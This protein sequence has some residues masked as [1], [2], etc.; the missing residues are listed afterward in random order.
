MSEHRIPRLDASA[1]DEQIRH[2]LEREGCVILEE[3]IDHETID[4][5]LSELRPY[6]ER[7]PTGNGDFSGFHTKRLHSLFT[8]S[9]VLAEFIL[10]PNVKQAVDVALLPYCDN[11]Q[12]NSNSI[13]AI[14]PAETVQPLHR[15]DLLYPLSHPSERNAC[16]TAFWALTDFTEENGATR[17]I[18]G[19]HHWDDLRVPEES[20]T[21]QAVMPKGSV[22][23]FVG[24]VYHGGG[25]NRTADEW[26]IGMFQGYCLGWLRQEQN[27]YLSVPPDEARKMPEELA[28]LLGYSVHRPYLGWVFDLQDPWQVING[29]EELSRG[30]GRDMLARGEERMEQGRSVRRGETPTARTP[31]AVNGG[32]RANAIPAV[33][34]NTD[35]AEMQGLLAEAGCLIVRNVV[36]ADTIDA[37]LSDLQ[38]WLERKPKGET[39]FIGRETKR[40]F[41]LL[42]KT[43]R[44][45]DFIGHRTVLDLVDS[46]LGPFCDHFQLSTNSI[47]AI[48]P[49]ETAQSLH[50]GDALYPLPH[51]SERNLSCTAVWALGDFSAENGATLIVPGS[52]RWDD[53]RKPKESE[54]VPAAMPKG[55]VCL[56][57]GGTYHG[58][59][60]NRSAHQW[61]IG[62]FQGY[63][64]GWLRQEQN[65]YLT[66]P[67]E[68]AREMPEHIGRLLGYTLHRP[69]LGW[70]QDFQDPWDA[71]N[72]YEELSSGGSDL[73]ASG[74]SRPI[75]GESVRVV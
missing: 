53:T 49:G 1:S 29:Y 36:E 28:R 7:K 20:E 2:H 25:A 52:H 40:L 45:I 68:L 46:A 44:V 3:V 21:V 4:R 50:R 5:M 27:F 37:L 22:C 24:G 65:F 72:G 51:P 15:D 12:L 48:G 69:F 13:T 67:P 14:G 35:P 64:L 66:V 11:Y 26:R 73:F 10:H 34:A 56:F 31:A 9:S 59:G 33:D 18:P 19:S 23:F 63:C 39:E 55:S 70:V 30:G 74:A 6:M 61:R 38:P 62:M 71:I 32:A 17:I 41:S 54:A 43:R 47:T 60:A 58:G 75:Q 8:K 16:C 57:L 42:P